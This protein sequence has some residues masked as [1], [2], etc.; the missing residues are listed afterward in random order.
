M[1]CKDKYFPECGNGFV[2]YS[3]YW[4]STKRLSPLLLGLLLICIFELY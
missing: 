2:I 4:V 1:G 3:L